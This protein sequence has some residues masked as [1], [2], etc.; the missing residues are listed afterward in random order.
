M[1][2][3]MRRTGAGVT[4]T[5]LALVMACAARAANT[6]WTY[7]SPVDIKWH[8]LTDLSTLLVG[9][10]NGIMAL[11]PEK[12]TP[13]WERTDLKKVAEFQ[14]EEI[15]ATPVL[16]VGVNEGGFSNKTKLV[17]LDITSG[18]TLWETEKVKGATVGVLPIYPKSLVVVFTSKNAGASKDKPDMIALDMLTGEIK[19]QTE[20]PDNVDLQLADASGKFFQ[21]YD[22][23]GYEDPVYEGDLAFFTY[24]GLHCFD[25]N[26]GKLVYGVPYDVTEKTYKKANAQAIIDSDVIYTSAKGVIR[27]HD[28]ATG[29]VKWVSKDFG[30]GVAQMAIRGNI[31][32]CRMGGQFYEYKDREWKLAKPLGIVAVDKT[33]GNV[34]W[35]YD[36]A[37]DG[38]TNI[39][40]LP[41]QDVVL[42]ADSKSMIGLDAAGNEVFRVPLEFKHKFGAGAKAAKAG[43]KFMRGGALAFAKKD[44]SDLDLPVVIDMRE[45]G[46]AVV[47][48]AQHAL[49]F[50]PETKEIAWSTSFPAPSVSGWKLAVMAG[51]TAL[52]YGY[53]YSR[54]SH[55]Q[56]GTWENTQ[57]NDAKGRAM[58]SYEKLFN[59]RYTA[60]KASGGYAYVLTEI[61]EGKD[62]KGGGLVGLNLNTGE[63]E[64]QVLLKMKEP[65]YEVDELEGR[66]FNIKDKKEFTAY[67]IK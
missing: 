39:A 27:A 54:A 38:I 8:K 13:I 65:D 9:T 47:R 63:V 4:A 30:G 37:K 50:N 1:K 34:L 45:N 58:A 18:E 48:G 40:L 17:G 19:W 59:K 67:S 15:K 32:Y 12:G 60:T 33:T 49:A 7:K 28:K 10:D 5:I 41:N 31:I 2:Q 14:V 52:Q 29:A 66:I 56:L 55:S 20:F 36:K 23:S 11:D 44:T 62:N 21:K 3:V 6:L 57:A 64:H 42:L 16:L 24:R 46:T 53:H 51:L 61:D 25:L 35:K 43:M 22:L 26:T